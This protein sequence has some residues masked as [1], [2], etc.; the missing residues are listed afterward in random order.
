L[1]SKAYNFLELDSNYGTKD[2][3]MPLMI[4]TIAK[5]DKGSLLEICNKNI[6]NADFMELSS[7]LDLIKKNHIVG[8]KQNLLKRL[9]TKNFPFDIFQITE[10]LLSFKDSNTNNKLI[11][12]LREKRNDW[13]SGN[14]SEAFRELLA[15]NKLELN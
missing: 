12:I 3:I 15:K 14:W 9:K 2:S 4:E 11:L 13:D 7:V 8:T 5:Y 1:N 10:T 6:E